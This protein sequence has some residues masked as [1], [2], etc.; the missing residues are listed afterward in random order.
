MICDCGTVCKN[1]RGLVQ[2]WHRGCP[3]AILNLFIGRGKLVRAHSISELTKKYQWKAAKIEGV[4]RRAL[5][6]QE[7]K[8]EKEI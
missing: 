4:L 8:L 5:I 6:H 7:L 1:Y 3:T 2:H